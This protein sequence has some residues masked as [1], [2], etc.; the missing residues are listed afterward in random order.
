[1]KRPLVLGI[2]GGI[3]SGKSQVTEILESHGALVIDADRIGHQV[4]EDHA[5]QTLLVRQFGQSVLSQEAK[6][7]DR[8]RVA[9]LVF[10]DTPQAIQRRR[11][12]EAIT[13][14]PIRARIRQQ[15]DE[16]LRSATLRWIVLDVP[17]L[18]ESGWDKSCDA[19]WFVDAP[20]D[21]RLQRVLVRGWTREHFLA[22]EASQWS[23]DRKRSRA[24]HVISNSGSLEELDEQV[25]KMLQMRE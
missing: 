21:I 4:L 16:A 6:S 22:R 8:K 12:L 7:V 23:V 10:G 3:A 19:V 25:T 1:M 20:Q 11:A 14:P 2:T 17:L 5:V 9:E 13:H 15:L 18:L 24:T